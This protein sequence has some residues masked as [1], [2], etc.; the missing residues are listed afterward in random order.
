MKTYKVYPN[1]NIVSKGEIVGTIPK[2]FDENASYANMR[3]KLA[4][5]LGLTVDDIGETN[6]VESFDM[7]GKHECWVVSIN[8]RARHFKDQPF[9]PGSEGSGYE[10]KLSPRVLKVLCDHRK[11]LRYP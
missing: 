8:D 3:A 11:A 9:E 6:I 10:P 4:E 2:K 5:A 1:A 7:A